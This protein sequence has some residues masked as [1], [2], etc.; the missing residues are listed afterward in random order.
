MTETYIAKE[1][2]RSDTRPIISFDLDMTLLNHADRKI[3]ESALYA[4]RK[5][6][7]NYRI[8]IATGRDMDAAY[9][10]PYRDQI[11]PDAVIHKNGA[12]VTV[13]DRVL[14]QSFMSRELKQELLDFADAHGLAIGITI[15]DRDYYTHP[16]RV[17]EMDEKY[18]GS[19]GRQYQDP[20]QLLEM[21]DLTALVYIG[22]PEGSALLERTF[23]DFRLPRFATGAGADMIERRHSKAKGLQ[24]LCEYW[25]VDIADTYAFGDSMND[26]EILQAAGH[27]IA[28]GNAGEELRILAD[29]VTRRID[30]DGILYACRQLGLLRDRIIFFDIDGTLMRAAFGGAHPVVIDAIRQAQRQGYR[31]MIASGRPWS[32]IAPDV[33]E[34]GFDGY[35]LAN[36]AQIRLEGR[37]A[38]AHILDPAVTAELIRFLRE[39][40]IEYSILDPEHAYLDPAFARYQ[41]FYET[42]HV[43]FSTFIYAFD[44]AE[45]L[46]GA[47]KMECLTRSPQESEAVR[48]KLEALGLGENTYP[49]SVEVVHPDC[50]KGLAIR[51]AMELC[52]IDAGQSWCFGDGINDLDMFAAVAHPIAMGNAIPELKALAESVCPTVDEDGIAVKLRQMFAEEAEDPAEAGTGS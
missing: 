9:S 30:R 14:Y 3:P 48:K 6:R 17:T 2:S 51:R 46:K 49:F 8:V 28:M 23:P 22:E 24:L 43:D 12:K 45:V 39:N 15:G 41:A 20:Y 19:C 7:P 47:V 35:I 13:G 1:Q 36:G 33:R 5:L 29:F 27:S 38:E 40:G 25:G 26:L 52:G 50:S 32:F 18:W 16:E 31:C 44:E 21:E 42:A 4:I 37:T 34:I 10:A 11:C